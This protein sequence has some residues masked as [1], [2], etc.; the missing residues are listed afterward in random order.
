MKSETYKKIRE[1][2]IR[3]QK[4]VQRCDKLFSCLQ[5]SS[6]FTFWAHFQVS[7]HQTDVCIKENQITKRCF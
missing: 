4:D 7:A 3:D 1:N 5:I 2:K 6:V